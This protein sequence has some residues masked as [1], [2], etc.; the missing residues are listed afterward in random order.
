[1]METTTIPPLDNLD[2]ASVVELLKKEA[3][4][5]KLSSSRCKISKILATFC[6]IFSQR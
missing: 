4:S 6:L 2:V 5:G 3:S 1:M